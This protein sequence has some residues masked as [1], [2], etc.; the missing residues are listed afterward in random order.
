M[1]LDSRFDFLLYFLFW[2]LVICHLLKNW[3]LACTF[4]LTL[5]SVLCRFMLPSAG[6]CWNASQLITLLSVLWY[7]LK[8]HMVKF[9]SPPKIMSS[10]CIKDNKPN[11]FHFHY[12]TINWYT[13]HSIRPSSGSQVKAWCWYAAFYV[14]Q[15]YFIY[16]VKSVY[17]A[18]FMC[19]HLGI[20]YL[21]YAGGEALSSG[22]SWR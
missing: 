16:N 5:K 3:R 19:F 15:Q 11:H 18:H 4:S 22:E 13:C 1:R 17:Q 2:P 10:S 14:L 8:C 9:L 6:R 12:E 21:P 20:S 7:D